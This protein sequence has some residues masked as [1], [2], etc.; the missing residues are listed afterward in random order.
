MSIISLQFLGALLSASCLASSVTDYVP[1]K[2]AGPSQVSRCAYSRVC[3]VAR[4]LFS[5][6]LPTPLLF[7]W[8]AV[9]SA[10]PFLCAQYRRTCSVVLVLY[11]GCLLDVPK[12]LQSRRSS[13]RRFA[14]TC[15]SLLSLP[16]AYTT[17]RC[18]L[19]KKYLGGPWEFFGFLPWVVMARRV[20]VLL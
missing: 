11:L 16:V 3:G 8:C 14:L 4:P 17:C 9:V 10:A 12:P 5:G 2:L 20:V 19:C 7:P 13:L 18:L 1:S 6:F 15:L